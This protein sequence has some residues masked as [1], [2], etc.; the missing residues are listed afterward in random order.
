MSLVTMESA[1]FRYAEDLRNSVHSSSTSKNESLGV[2][3]I[4]ITPSIQTASTG[5]PSGIADNFPISPVLP[6]PSNFPAASASTG[7]SVSRPSLAELRGYP[8]TA[9]QGQ[10]QSLF[11]PHP[12]A[13][14]APL[15]SPGP[16]YIRKV[17][18]FPQLEPN[19]IRQGPDPNKV[20]SNVL[21]MVLNKPP[22]PP[23]PVMLPP[24][25]SI[26][27]RGNIRR[28]P[29]A[30][31]PPLPRGPTIYARVDVDLSTSNG[32]V[33][34]TFSV[35]PMGPPPPPLLHSQAAI[36]PDASL[37][38]LPPLTSDQQQEQPQLPHMSAT[39]VKRSVTVPTTS[40]PRTEPQSEPG[41][42]IPKENTTP[43]PPVSRPRSKSFSTGFKSPVVGNTFS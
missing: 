40:L 18:N 23:R 32:P 5:S 37:H 14:K 13:P 22:P 26:P 34:I 19:P 38:Q 41:G 33:P 31:P 27:I 39:H 30:P 1:E 15:Q 10:R 16:L 3:P 25:S 12:N 2:T 42:V 8:N 9:V 36:Q 24:P 35:E 6:P 43:R 17:E 4:V 11:L 7:Q 20:A 21:R 28:N 29:P